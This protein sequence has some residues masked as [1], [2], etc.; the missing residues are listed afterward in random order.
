[1]NE[2]KENDEDIKIETS[3]P[4]IFNTSIDNLKAAI[5]GESYETDTMYPEFAAIALEE[6]LINIA[7]HLKAIAVAEKNHKEKYEL[8][9]KNIE[10]NEVFTKTSE[11]TWVCRECGYTHTG[12]EAP[13]S[14]P[15]CDHPQAFYEI[16]NINF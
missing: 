10:N 1:M 12:L 11:T 15:S 3:V 16:R 2:L 6:G 14:C 9:L 4:T 13:K 8:Y 7:S 5:A